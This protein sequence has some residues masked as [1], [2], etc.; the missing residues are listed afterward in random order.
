MGKIKNK[1]ITG[2][3]LVEL[4]A[5]IIILGI[6]ITIAVPSVT[7]IL[8]ASKRQA[9]TEYVEKTIK[10]AETTSV[11][12]LMADSS[13]LEETC[14]MYNIK[15]DLDLSET[16]DFDGWILYNLETDKYYITIYNKDFMLINYEF[17]ENSNLA[18]AISSK[19]VPYKKAE[20]EKIREQVKKDGINSIFKIKNEAGEEVS[21]E[22]ETF[23]EELPDESDSYIEG[24][25]YLISGKKFNT[26]IKKLFPNEDKT[27]NFTTKDETLKN[28]IFT[29]KEPAE[30]V[31]TIDLS[32]GTS[33]NVIKAYVS[34]TDLYIYTTASTVY[35]PQDASYM[36]N[37]FRELVKIT[38]D[39]DDDFNILGN[40]KGMIAL[41]YMFNNCYKL[42]KTFD[43]GSFDTKY[44]TDMSYM[45]NNCFELTDFNIAN[46]DT[47]NV[48]YFNFTFY[49]CL[50]VSTL[51]IGKWSGKSV[52]STS[53]MFQKCVK[54][55]SIDMT[56]FSEAT[57]WNSMSSMFFECV[58]LTEIKGI[59]RFKTES[60]SLFENMFNHCNSLKELD[61]SGWKI[62]SKNNVNMYHMFYN[63]TALEH[64]YASYDW[65]EDLKD[66]EYNTTEMFFGCYALNFWIY[67]EEQTCY[68]FVFCSGPGWV[69]TTADM[70]MK[71][72][73]LANGEKV[74]GIDNLYLGGKDS[75]K[76]K[77]CALT[78]KAAP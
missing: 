55:T 42:E 12:N 16:G 35:L 37:N 56:G 23:E 78:Y 65:A 76:G 52:V 57:N 74:N 29:R 58:L 22:C 61:L 19:T 60:V 36:F 34:D 14:Y 25:A 7:G 63:A 69:E 17:T 48:K 44:V 77:N 11:K 18:E 66:H 38:D 47:A 30:G 67:L 28:I 51:P 2:F 8:K 46:F 71:F 1:G 26:A 24:R 15:K 39:I 43:L 72:L 3:T 40:P 10:N 68:Y 59:E 50:K 32:N 4:L 21:I 70:V 5:V 53:S 45:F 33:K 73:G 31:S 75:N 9:F 54:L 49:K 6:L 41:E 27:I 20:I 13:K 62:N 64:I